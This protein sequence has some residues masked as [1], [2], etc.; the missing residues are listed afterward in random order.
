[1]FTKYSSLVRCN[2]EVECMERIVVGI[3]LRILT[4]YLFLWR[5]FT[6][7]VSP[8]TPTRQHDYHF[9]HFQSERQNAHS[10]RLPLPKYQISSIVVRRQ[11]TFHPEGLRARW[12]SYRT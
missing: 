2:R 11:S 3:Y 1:M 9:S 8:K 5:S 7:S 4:F 6:S 12:S 10:K